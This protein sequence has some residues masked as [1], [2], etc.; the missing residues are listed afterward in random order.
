MYLD[1][2]VDLLDDLCSHQDPILYK[3]AETT[4]EELD[5]LLTDPYLLAKDIRISYYG[6]APFR[7]IHGTLSGMVA[8]RKRLVGVRW[9]AS[10]REDSADALAR[11]NSI[12]DRLH[13]RTTYPKWLM[14]SLRRLVLELEK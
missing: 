11:V 4:P 14:K 12:I 2:A 10:H 8:D 13:E 3:G 5:Y 6:G 7:L 1:S 9:P